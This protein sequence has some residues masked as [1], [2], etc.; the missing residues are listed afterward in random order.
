MKLIYKGTY[1]KGRMEM[2]SNYSAETKNKWYNVVIESR[3]SISVNQFALGIDMEGRGY[4]I[5]DTDYLKEYWDV[6]DKQRM[7]ITDKNTFEKYLIKH[8]F[9]E[10]EQQPTTN[11]S[12]P[13]F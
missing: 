7:E 5:V 1:E 8:G 2:Y 10:L 4:F 12:T 13:A 9:V 3:I 11:V 6:K